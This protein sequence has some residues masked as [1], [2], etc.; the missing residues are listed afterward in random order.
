MRQVMAQD[1]GLWKR[2][3]LLFGLVA[4][5]AL[6]VLIVLLRRPEAPPTEGPLKSQHVVAA[7]PSPVAAGVGT[8]PWPGYFHLSSH[9]P[10]PEGWQIRYSAAISLARSGSK[11]LSLPILREML[12]EDLQKRNY[13]VL[14]KDGKYT[15]NTGA[16]HELNIN[17]LKAFG[18]WH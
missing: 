6:V 8:L 12:N 15:I 5:I 16:A 14:G 4:L 7:L 1:S 2:G 11:K 3:M 13:T 9:L 10:S 18:E 17:A